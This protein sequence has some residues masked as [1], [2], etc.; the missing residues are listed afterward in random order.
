MPYAVPGGYLSVKLSKND[1]R[2][3]YLV[4]QLVAKAF[5]PARPGVH[6]VNHIDG[7]KHNNCVRNLEWATPQE[8][9]QHAWKNGLVKPMS[10]IRNG[11]AKLT[12]KKVRA[13]RGLKGKVRQI[14]LARK[15]GVAKSTIWWIQSG[16]HWK[17]AC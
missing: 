1:I 5:L 16:R 7:D 8:N 9:M 13:I 17:T 4:H 14:D 3:S 6:T 15:Y 10:G 12:P 2:K 11:M